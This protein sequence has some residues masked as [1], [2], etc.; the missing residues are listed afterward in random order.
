MEG[1]QSG[2]RAG[3]SGTVD[4]L[5]I[6]QIVTTDCH[7]GRRNLS[8]VWIAVEKAYDSVDHGWLQCEDRYPFPPD[9][10]F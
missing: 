2:A 9:Q 4:T 7:R 10:D 5:L 3:C 8:V 6:D 1:A